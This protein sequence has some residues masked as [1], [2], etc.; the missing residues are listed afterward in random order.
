LQIIADSPVTTARRP[1]FLFVVGSIKTKSE[2]QTEEE[3]MRSSTPLRTLEPDSEEIQ[4]VAYQ[5]YMARGCE[6]G[7]DLDDWLE[8]ERQLFREMEMRK[9]A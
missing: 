2:P 7:Y 1:D 6:D 4:R 8:A 3:M 9:A 5:L